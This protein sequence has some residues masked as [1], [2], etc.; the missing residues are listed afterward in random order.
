MVHFVRCD[1]VVVFFFLKNLYFW[2]CILKYLL[3]KLTDVW[4]LPQNNLGHGV[5][6][7]SGL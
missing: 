6:E 1:N 3:M 4:D 7:A 5:G 2:R